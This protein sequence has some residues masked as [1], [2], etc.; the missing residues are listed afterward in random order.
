[1]VYIPKYEL[2]RIVCEYEG[3]VVEWITRGKS[4]VP[5]LTERG[6]EVLSI[7]A[8]NAVTMLGVVG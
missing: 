1:M 5:W 7:A 4:M 8:A 2:T 6:Y 3:E